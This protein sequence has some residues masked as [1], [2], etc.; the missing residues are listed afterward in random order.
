MIFECFLQEWTES[1][2]NDQDD[3]LTWWESFLRQKKLK[4]EVNVTESNKIEKDHMI[5]QTCWA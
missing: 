4:K 2:K 1:E 3:V 5:H